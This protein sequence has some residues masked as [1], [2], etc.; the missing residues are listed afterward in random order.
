MV[1]AGLSELRVM[2]AVTTFPELRVCPS[3]P[4][5]ETRSLYAER[6][7]KLAMGVSALWLGPEV[8]I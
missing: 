7:Q 3:P 6:Y 4:L 1:T 8:Q 5:L 2:G